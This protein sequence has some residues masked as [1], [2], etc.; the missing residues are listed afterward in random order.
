MVIRASKHASGCTIAVVLLLLCCCVFPAGVQSCTDSENLGLKDDGFQWS[1]DLNPFNTLYKEWWFFTLVDEVADIAWCMGYAVQDPQQELDNQH[2]GL[3]GMLWPKFKAN[4]SE[5]HILNDEYALSAFNASRTEANVLIGNQNSITVIDEKTYLLEGYSSNSSMQWSLKY[6][7]LTPGCRET[8]QVH[9]VVTL[10][11]ISYM[12]SAHVSGYIMFQGKNTT[13]NAKGYHD[14]NWGVWPESIFNW[15][16]AQYGNAS[17]ELSVTLGGYNIPETPEYVGYVFVRLA[18]KDGTMSQ[19]KVGTLCDDTF[20]FIP[21]QFEESDGHKYSV[22]NH[23]E[24]VGSEI[25]VI[26]DYDMVVSGVNP[27]G[28]GLELLVFEQ[29]SNFHV[30]ILQKNANGQWELTHDAQG[31]GFNEWSDVIRI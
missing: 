9:D 19:F 23:V 6:E 29:L 5:L 30:Q 20:K 28:K 17:L 31:L 7:Q 22:K 11:W 26:M 25:T 27:G 24:A 16:W 2:A 15:V 18:N 14:H 12:P 21:L 1:K 3:A 13:I 4:P 8:M 10:D